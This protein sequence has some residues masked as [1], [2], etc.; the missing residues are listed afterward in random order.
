MQDGKSCGQAAY[1]LAFESRVT[2][3]SCHRQVLSF[4]HGYKRMTR[5]FQRCPKSNSVEFRVE[6]D[7]NEHDERVNVLHVCTYLR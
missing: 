4:C 2:F 6:I 1:V 3:L 7:V 5:T